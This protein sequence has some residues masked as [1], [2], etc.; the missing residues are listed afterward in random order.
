MYA[1]QRFQNEASNSMQNIDIFVPKEHAG[2]DFSKSMQIQADILTDA[3]INTGIQGII[4]C[5]F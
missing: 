4:A 5:P 3:T 2:D 1:A